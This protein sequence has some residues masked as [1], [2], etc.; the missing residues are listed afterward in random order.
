MN[1]TLFLHVWKSSRFSV[2]L[3]DADEISIYSRS[4]FPAADNVEGSGK[5]KA[6]LSDSSTK[7]NTA[8]PTVKI[9]EWFEAKS[10]EGYSYYW[11]IST[12]GVYV[13]LSSVCTPCLRAHG[14]LCVCPCLPSICTPCVCVYICVCVTVCVFAQVCL[15]H[16][17]H[18][19]I[20][21]CVFLC[22]CVCPS[23]TCTP[24][25]CNLR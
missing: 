24:H 21:V 8:A 3:G 5:E 22:L 15:A 13:C 18:V 2:Y 25:L 1:R 19:Y 16:V 12:N 6:A 23:S 7:P 4:C 14:C 9:K 20:G 17:H 11:N 10:P